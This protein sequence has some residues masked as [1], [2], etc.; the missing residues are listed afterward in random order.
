ME[1]IYIKVYIL[2]ISWRLTA[3]VSQLFTDEKMVDLLKIS[4]VLEEHP[5]NHTEVMEKI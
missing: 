2:D 3:A 4:G 1:L 5:P